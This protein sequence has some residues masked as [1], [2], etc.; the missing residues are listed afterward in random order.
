MCLG[1]CVCLYVCVS[2]CDCVW[3]SVYTSACVCL[4]VCVCVFVCVHVYEHVRGLLVMLQHAQ[5]PIGIE[6][7]KNEFIDIDS[8]VPVLFILYIILFVLI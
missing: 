5:H 7:L 3:V 2:V 1:V 4:F 8:I 6:F